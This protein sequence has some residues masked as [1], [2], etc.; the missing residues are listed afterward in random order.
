MG[1]SKYLN[2]LAKSEV[3]HPHSDICYEGPVFDKK[4]KKVFFVLG[5]SLLRENE[6]LL[7]QGRPIQ[8]DPYGRG[9]L[10][11]PTPAYQRRQL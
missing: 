2:F 6:A 1:S 5:G 7:Q 10:G 9:S 8:I 3:M 11:R 4:F